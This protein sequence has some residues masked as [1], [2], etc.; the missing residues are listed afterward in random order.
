MKALRSSA[1]FGKFPA[2]PG[3]ALAIFA[4]LLCLL[5]LGVF[6]GIDNRIYDLS[7]R[8]RG[9]R[10]APADIVIVA[11]D[12]ESMASLGRWPWPRKKVA[13]FV[14]ILSQ[15]GA[16]VIGLDIF[17]PSAE[18]E[19]R[20]GNDRI[21]AD[22]A[23]RAGNVVFPYY[24]TIGHSEPGKGKRPELPAEVASSAVPG[25]DVVRKLSAVPFVPAKEIFFPDPEISRGARGM[26]HI[27]VLPDP[28]GKV[29]RETLLI[30][31]D[32]RAYPSFSLEV[33]ASA[34]SA[35]RRDLKVN[36]GRFLAMGEKEIPIEA[37]GQMLIPY[38]G[39]NQTIRYWSCKDLLSGRIPASQI[40]GKI[41]LV[42]VT[43]ASTHDFLATPFSPRVAGV[44]KHAQ[45]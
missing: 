24:F 22:S 8:A 26:G 35:D 12:D 11:I 13:E 6:D 10:P 20:S 41:V 5:P 32:R 36:R 18:E 37:W 16:R 29:R 4:A 15:G 23:A 38:L 40:R 17:F 19:K 14:D 43:A 2:L 39:G 3:T 28:D 42:G 27:N 30:E 33:A 25:F 9:T 34:L 1:F 44:E 31:Y 45:T 21:L 7:I